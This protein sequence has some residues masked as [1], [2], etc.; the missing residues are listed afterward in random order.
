MNKENIF[1]PEDFEYRKIKNQS[2]NCRGCCG[3]E[4]E[5]EVITAS[6]R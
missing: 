6:F 3:A 2:L 1:V 5:Y 4:A